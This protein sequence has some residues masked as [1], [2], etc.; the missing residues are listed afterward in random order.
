MKKLICFFCIFFIVV[1]VTFVSFAGELNI[2]N[3]M[4]G[5]KDASSINTG[6]IGNA[7]NIVIAFLQVS[8]LGIAIIVVTLLGVKYML[9][10]VGEKVEI[11]KKEVVKTD[12]YP[13]S[14]LTFA[15]KMKSCALLTMK[16]K[17]GWMKSSA[18]G[19]R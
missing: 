19:F 18:Y 17:R 4:S 1:F 11:K 12:C 2:I 14:E 7:L 6:G 16:S 10:S 13:D 15:D 3:N 8:G 5:I 9:G